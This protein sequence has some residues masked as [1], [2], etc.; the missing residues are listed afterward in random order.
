MKLIY[1]HFNIVANES[2]NYISYYFNLYSLYCS[3]ET[4]TPNYQKVRVYLMCGRV[5]RFLVV[6]ILLAV[7]CMN[8]ADIT[9]QGKYFKKCNFIKLSC[10]DL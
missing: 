9:E 2:D 10:H 7:V 8:E 1:K 6:L 3:M 4:V 5:A